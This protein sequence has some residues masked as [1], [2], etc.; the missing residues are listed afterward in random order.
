MVC[1]APDGHYLGVCD[2]SGVF[3]RSA[4]RKLGTVG[5]VVI[6]VILLG[7]GGMPWLMT[8]GKLPAYVIEEDDKEE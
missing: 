3:Q 2:L 5:Y 8:T 6:T 4:P 7:V 1:D